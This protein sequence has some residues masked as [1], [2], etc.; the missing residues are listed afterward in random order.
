MRKLVDSDIFES[1]L[2]KNDKLLGRVKMVMSGSI[3]GVVLLNEILWPEIKRK[4]ID[5]RKEK[6]INDMG[7]AIVD[8]RLILITMPPE[9]RISDNLPFVALKNNGIRCVLVNLST[10]VK[11]IKNPDL[12][13]DY[14]MGDNVV[15]IHSILYAAF[16]AL[17]KL[18]ERTILSTN[19]MYDSAVIWAEMFNKPIYD[20]FGMNNSERYIAFKYFAMKF[21][22]IYFLNCDEKTAESIAMKKI[23]NKNELINWM[24]TKI[25]EKGID[26]FHGG[27]VTY[28]TTIFN[29][30]ITRMQGIK[31]SN[32]ANTMNVSFYL[33]RF[34]QTYSSNA[35]LSLCAFPYFMY[36]IIS[37]MG[38]ANVVRDRA[39]DKIFKDNSR[40]VNRLLIEILKD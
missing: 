14:D 16:L 20:A 31:V 11:E 21:F 5:K 36:V 2:N 39:F 4:I 27:V 28:L 7:Q 18:D 34:V 15:K 13:I 6:F 12:T 26:I 37:A 32:V 29:S 24:E 1:N 23:Q 25:D 19:T 40:E 10:M 17:E 8:G 33:T 30:E 9:N 22:L 3:P 38:K 35:I